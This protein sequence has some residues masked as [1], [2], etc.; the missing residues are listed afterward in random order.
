MECVVRNS[1]ATCPKDVL[2][3][4]DDPLLALDFEDGLLGRLSRLVTRLS[5]ES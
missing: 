5:T 2:I 4:E 3:V 1:F